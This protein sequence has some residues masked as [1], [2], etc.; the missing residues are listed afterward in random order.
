MVILAS[1]ICDVLIYN[2]AKENPSDF[3]RAISQITEQTYYLQNKGMMHSA[4]YFAVTTKRRALAKVLDVLSS[5]VSDDV[6]DSILNALSIELEKY[7]NAKD[8]SREQTGFYLVGLLNNSMRVRNTTFERR[9]NAI[10]QKFS[11]IRESLHS[12]V[13]KNKTDSSIWAESHSKLS[14]EQMP[15]LFPGGKR[16]SGV[17]M[18]GDS[19][20]IRSS[21]NEK[22]KGNIKLS[23]N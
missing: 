13:Q 18:H 23:A 4:D 10:D 19:D 16:Y 9:K 6:F 21:T 7:S 5:N 1:N 3:V 20:K 8:A 22:V 2:N 14:N 11:T 15:Y 12:L 17:F